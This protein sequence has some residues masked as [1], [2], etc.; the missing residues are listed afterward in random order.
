[1]APEQALGGK[2]KVGPATDV[3][4]LGAILFELLTGRPPFQSGQALETILQ[5]VSD[6]PPSP[7]SL[8]PSVPRDL[9]TICLKCLAKA[10]AQRYAGAA[11][12]ADDLERYREGEP[13][14]ARR[15]YAVERLWRW[16]KEQPGVAFRMALAF[17]LMLG[18]S[19][20]FRGGWA[21]LMTATATLSLFQG[22]RLRVAAVAAGVATA[23]LALAAAT[24]LYHDPR[25][26]QNLFLELEHFFAQL[27]PHG[28]PSPG[29]VVQVQLMTLAFMGPAGLWNLPEVMAWSL[30]RAAR[31]PYLAA[32]V[33]SG[34]LFLGVTV[35]FGARHEGWSMRWCVP[36]LAILLVAGLCYGSGTSSALISG[37]WVGLTV[38]AVG[39][40]VAY[41]L[42]RDRV[43][44][45][46]GAI[47]GT[48]LGLLVVLAFAT[49]AAKNPTVA[50]LHA[51]SPPGVLFQ[52]V[53][54][55]LVVMTFG[56]IRG[57]LA[58]YPPTRRLKKRWADE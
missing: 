18:L 22:A 41:L 21:W 36:I 10:P 24:L 51:D 4:A 44:A 23:L 20:L 55:F 8:R 19:L 31:W 26:D 12:L 39:R 17:S 11:E 5:V 1:M 16:V 37:V 14:R 56:S 7:R 58:A 27:G 48:F 45:L 38:A 53:F 34:G 3:Y 42:R 35:G 54:I 49:V 57:A 40:V 46:Q 13:I 2:A 33:L 15:E 47:F 28:A 30:W 25:A 29:M 52:T 50:A 6:E 43:A 9:E 32:L